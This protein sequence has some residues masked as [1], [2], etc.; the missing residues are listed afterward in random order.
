VLTGIKVELKNL[1]AYDVMPEEV[2]DLMAQRPIVLQGKYKGD[3]SSGQIK[4]TGVSGSGNFSKTLEIANASSSEKTAPL[5]A[6]WARRWVSLLDDQMAMLPGDK[7]L[8]EA[9]TSLGLQYSILTSYTS[10]VAVDSEVVNKGG[11]QT[12]VNQPLPLP[13]GVSN[14][15]VG[16]GSGG[17][18]QASTG[19][20]P[21]APL[22]AAEYAAPK[23]M[24][25]KGKS[26]DESLVDFDKD[27]KKSGSVSHSVTFSTQPTGSKLGLLKRKHLESVVTKVLEKKFKDGK[28]PGGA[29]LSFTFT[30]KLDD[31][32][33][34]SMSMSGD[35]GYGVKKALEAELKSLSGYKDF[36]SITIT[37]FFSTP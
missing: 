21:A 13:E 2:P 3:A 1:D 22:A 9:I 20:Y 30:L 14:Y 8:K 16:G 11:G 18:A 4:I 23:G 36:D 24:K 6:L 34:S 17:M 26:S 32:S 19:Y 25:Y 29:T 10:F 37:V 27:E 15:A 5:R 12:T 35:P 31:G 28:I 33:F 7:E